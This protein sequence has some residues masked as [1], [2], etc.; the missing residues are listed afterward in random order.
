MLDSKPPPPEEI[1][2]PKSEIRNPKKA[3]SVF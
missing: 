2:M 3:T 1:R